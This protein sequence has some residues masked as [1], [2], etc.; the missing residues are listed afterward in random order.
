M[1]AELLS[2]SAV[3]G[4]NV[5]LCLFPWCQWLCRVGSLLSLAFWVLVFG[6]CQQGSLVS[7]YGVIADSSSECW[8][9]CWLDWNLH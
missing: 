5:V 1:L 9:L 2:L 3:A 7:A 8:C 6:V 4:L